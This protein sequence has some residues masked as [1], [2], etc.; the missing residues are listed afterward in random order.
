MADSR[1]AQTAKDRENDNLLEELQR[2]LPVTESQAVDEID[3]ITKP[4]E[5]QKQDYQSKV[6]GLQNVPQMSMRAKDKAIS[7][8]KGGKNAKAG[9]DSNDVSKV[10]LK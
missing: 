1:G 7:K 3:M 5:L 10:F 8:G 6:I 9:D 4:K 2:D